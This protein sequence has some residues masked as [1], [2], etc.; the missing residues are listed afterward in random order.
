MALPR[1]VKN[2]NAFLDGISY[3]GL[4][5]EGKLPA[6]KIQTEAHR[7]AGMDG[8]VG[9]DMGTEGMTAELTFSEWLPAVV[10]K[11]GRQER[12]VIR[13]AMANPS[14]FGATTVIATM[15]GLITV[16]EPDA[17]KPGTGSKMKLTMD[18]RAYKLEIG[19]ETLVEIDFVNAIRRIGGV[20]QLAEIRRA[21]GL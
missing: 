5:E 7:G 6:V 10:K 13:P 11:L 19:G 16:A 8:P 1:I 15:S 17:L 21:M 9:L 20:D 3:F 4:V 2:F 18:L 12:L 14:D